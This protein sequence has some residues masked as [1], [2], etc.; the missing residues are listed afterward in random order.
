MSFDPMYAQQPW[1]VLRAVCWAL[2]PLSTKARQ[3]LPMDA[4]QPWA[5][6]E[7][8]LTHLMNAQQPWAVC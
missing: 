5:V 6:C 1:A 4:L 8:L 7:A 2:L 3:T